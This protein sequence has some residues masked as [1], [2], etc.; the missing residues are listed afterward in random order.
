MPDKNLRVLVVEDDVHRHA[1]LIKL[2]AHLGYKVV[3][4]TTLR[5]AAEALH[6]R[7]DCCVLD[8]MLPDGNGADLLAEI[9]QQQLTIKVAIATAA[10]GE[11]LDHVQSLSPDSYFRKPVDVPALMT[12]LRDMEFRKREIAA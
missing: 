7:P 12:W 1:S 8:L 6:S 9:R 3:G 5:E 10:S 4:V 11:M 2:I